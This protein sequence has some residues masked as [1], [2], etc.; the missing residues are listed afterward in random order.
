MQAV[1]GIQ[2]LDRDIAGNDNLGLIDES[3]PI[4]FDSIRQASSRSS[5][6]NSQTDIHSLIRQA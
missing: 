5:E 1:E 4:S 6:G 2:A 3:L